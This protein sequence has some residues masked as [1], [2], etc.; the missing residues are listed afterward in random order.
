[1][2]EIG[3]EKNAAVSDRLPDIAAEKALRQHS[4][5]RQRNSRG[6]LTSSSGFL[7]TVKIKIVS[8]LLTTWDID[9][10]FTEISVF[11]WKVY[12]KRTFNTFVYVF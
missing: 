1:M 4:K 8:S 6:T 9:F 5:W 11:H 3:A 2:Q 12:K 10:D 7:Q